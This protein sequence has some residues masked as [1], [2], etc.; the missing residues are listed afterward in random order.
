MESW[1][2]W[3]LF[4][5]ISFSWLLPPDG[6]QFIFLLHDSENYL[7]ETELN[8]PYFHAQTPT[9]EIFLLLVEKYVGAFVW[10]PDHFWEKRNQ[11]PYTPHLWVK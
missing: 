7:L 10:S 5:N 8:A 4:Y 1:K 6:L 11:I 2:I 9:A 3:N